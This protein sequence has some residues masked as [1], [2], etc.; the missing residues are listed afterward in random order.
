MKIERI[1]SLANV[2]VRLQ[3]LA[4]ERSLRATGCDLP[5]S[6]IPFDET[7]FPL[8]DNAQWL[9]DD[10]LFALVKETGAVP[11]SRKYLA[12]TLPNCAFFDSDIIHRR[13]P[14]E[15]LAPLPNDVFVVADTEWNKGRWTFTAETRELYRSK[16][17]LWLLDNFNSGFFAHANPKATTEH[18]RAL[19]SEPQNWKLIHGK[20]PTAGEQPGANFLIHKN[21]V[22]VHNLCLPPYRMESTMACDYPEDFEPIIRKPNGPAFIHYAG[23]GRNLAVPIARLIFDH[24]TKAEA[25]EMTGEFERRRENARNHGRWPIW[26]R[27]A[28]RIVPWIDCRFE[29]GW[30]DPKVAT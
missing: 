22:E 13:D 7:R 25:A 29:F 2:K 4:M 28:R 11:V 19:L 17:T 16:S 18:V 20:D 12:L 6:V 27:L 26:A 24:L 14:S 3:F 21:G 8:P 30:R 23:H 9:E 1:I 15:W 5:L 10:A